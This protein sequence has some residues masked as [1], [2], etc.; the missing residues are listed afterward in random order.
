VV[1][2]NATRRTGLGSKVARQLR[3]DG[4]T[5]TSVGNWRRTL[6]S[7]TTVFSEGQPAAAATMVGDLPTGGS[8]EVPLSGMPSGKLVV[9]VGA[10]YPRN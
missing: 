10:D 6:V 9:V 2:L 8:I 7:N 5:V 4:W 1:V 3:A